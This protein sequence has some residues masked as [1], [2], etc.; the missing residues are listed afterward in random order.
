[1]SREKAF[2]REALPQ[3]DSLRDFATSLCKNRDRADDLVQETMLKALRYF[4]TYTEGTNCRAWLFQIC[5]HSYINDYRRKQYEPIAVDFQDRNSAQ[6]SEKDAD[7]E[8]ELHPKLRDDSSLRVH[9]G[10]LGDEVAGALEN[11]PLE[12]QT[13]VLLSDIEG[14]TYDE[15]AEFTA[16]PIGTVRSRIHRGRMMLARTL[17][18]YAR[19]QG[20]SP[21]RGVDRSRQMVDPYV[22]KS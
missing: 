11:L 10:Y 17:G 8:W 16:A 7:V 1:M 12:Y 5:K 21:R 15:I 22:Q 9:D 4:D 19:S 6:A 2:E 13:A 3:L 14:Y 20:F 18:S